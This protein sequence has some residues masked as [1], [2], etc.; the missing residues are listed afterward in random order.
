[1]SAVVYPYV[2]VSHSR[3]RPY[4]RRWRTLEEVALTVTRSFDLLGTTAFL[5]LHGGQQYELKRPAILP[6]TKEECLE[7]V[8]KQLSRA[9]LQ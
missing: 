9:G 3:G 8:R 1:M 6:W 4:K 5:V 2:T 7:E